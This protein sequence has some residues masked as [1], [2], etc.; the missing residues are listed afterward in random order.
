MKKI[1]LLAALISLFACK[2]EADKTNEPGIMDAVEG[3]NSLSKAGDAIKDN[4]KKIE[5]LKKLQPISKETFKEILVEQLGDLK[6]SS[7]TIGG[8]VEGLGTGIASYGENDKTVNVTIFDGAGESGSAMVAGT[9]MLLAMD[10]ESVDKTN[11]QKTEEIDGVK[12]LTTNNSDPEQLRSMIT[13][14]HNERFQV[15]VEGNKMQLNELKKYKKQLDLSK[16]K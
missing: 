6:R 2:N 1:I 10:T 16:L 13:F 5:A 15:T 9:Y 8:L 12:C 3:I 11:T 4:E 7:F 14:I